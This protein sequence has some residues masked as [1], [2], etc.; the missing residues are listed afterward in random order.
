MAFA[1]AAQLAKLKSLPWPSEARRK[2]RRKQWYGIILS[3][4]SGNRKPS[5]SK[6]KISCC[7]ATSGSSSGRAEVQPHSGF[8]ADSAG[9]FLSARRSGARRFRKGGRSRGN[10]S[11]KLLRR[12]HLVSVF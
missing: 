7:M 8:V 2:V 3:H 9:R 10:S 1:L 6:R 12:G 4:D 11:P 5:R